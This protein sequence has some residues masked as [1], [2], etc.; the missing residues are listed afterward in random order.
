M[1]EVNT[2]PEL[3]AVKAHIEAY[4]GRPDWVMRELTVTDMQ[5]DI[6][7]ISPSA[8]R[9]YYTLVTMGMGSRRMNVP[10]DLVEQKLDRAEL[11]L[12]LPADWQIGEEREEWYWPIRLLRELAHLPLEHGSWLGWGHTVDHGEPFAA[13]TALCGSILVSPQGVEDGAELCAIPG[14]EEVNFYQV[15]PLY[16]EEMAFKQ[17]HDAQALLERMAEV[18]FV[19]RIDRPSACEGES[20]Q[21][22]LLDDARWHLEDLRAKELPVEEIAA[23]N[24]LA[25]YLDWCVKRDLMSDRFNAS[26]PAQADRCSRGQWRI[27]LREWIRDVLDGR[28]L[29]SHFNAE[30]Q[31]FADWYYSG[32][33]AHYYPS[34]V[35]DYTLR[36]FGSTWYH[37]DTF[38][39]E[40]YLFVPYDKAY[41]HG[42]R[43]CLDRRWEQWKDS[44]RRPDKVY[45][46]PDEEIRPLLTGWTQAQG[47]RATD[48]IM[49]DGC[50]V[51]FCCREEPDGDWPDSGWRFTA[52][53]EDGGYMDDPANSGIYTLNTLCNYDPDI[54][55]LLDAPY[56]SAFYRDESGVFRAREDQT[57]PASL[58]GAE[59]LRAL[60]CLDCGDSAHFH[61]MLSYLD[62][63]VSSG[64]ADGRFTLDQACEDLQIALW[65]A[66]ACNNLDEYEHY[67]MASKWMPASEKN[68]HGCGMWYYRY[69]CALVYCGRLEQA[70]HYAEEGLKQEPGYPWGW[71]QAAKLRSHFGRRDA[72]LEAV[73]RGL[74]LAPGDYEFTTL[75]EEI[76][77]GSTLEEMEYHYI[78]P[79]SDRELRAGAMPD[80]GKRRR[81]V[82]G[83]VCNP[84]GI[85]RIKDRFRPDNWEAD[86]PYCGFV[87]PFHGRNIEY[88]FRVNE[89]A[90]SKMDADLLL[91]QK[92]GVEED[93]TLMYK[94][95]GGA[96]YQLQAV[97]FNQDY[98]VVL[99]YEDPT[100]ENM[101]RIRVKRSPRLPDSQPLP[102]GEYGA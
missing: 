40:A 88:I 34:D 96:C 61:K 51:G 69:S 79:A 82:S 36:Y 95:K 22:R 46:H 3:E 70:L 9:D 5:V 15:V 28:L 76:L 74:E 25:I 48:R 68:A 2:G 44:L 10:E 49:V 50:R 84:E 64:V 42:I 38:K 89:A 18:C 59:E 35:D 33:E 16:G 94:W 6:G 19:L 29:R 13:N 7:V 102:E 100:G 11:I 8:D 32:D 71:L 60:R 85:A 55:P 24:H 81:A 43:A 101:A 99:V 52:G 27:D 86:T 75:R 45:F 98:S 57:A 73:A 67:Y 20:A 12:C 41:Y 14:G 23:Y 47:C 65:Y 54:L 26:H 83:I 37:S 90:L 58:L 78:A 93:E 77:A 66:Y 97:L 80:E 53:D 72:A 17:A 63:F 56:G 91:K 31:A 30:G 4:F 1:E 21:E 92:R 39:G 62:H 87:A